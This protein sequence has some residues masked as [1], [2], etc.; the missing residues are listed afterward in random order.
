[1]KMMN[2][3]NTSAAPT[4]FIRFVFVVVRYQNILASVVNHLNPKAERSSFTY[5]FTL[6]LNNRDWLNQFYDQCP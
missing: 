1:M 4:I 2:C 3:G 5:I 6:T